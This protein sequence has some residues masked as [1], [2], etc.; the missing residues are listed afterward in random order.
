VCALLQQGHTTTILD[1][2][3]TGH[4]WATRGQVFLDV[5][6]RNPSALRDALRGLK[7]D[8]QPHH[9]EIEMIVATAWAWEQK[10]SS[11]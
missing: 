6:L 4:R 9:S 1:N 3:S 10:H 2:F 11:V 8:G 7:I 5:D